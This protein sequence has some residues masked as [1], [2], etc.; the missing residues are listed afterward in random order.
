MHMNDYNIGDEVELT[1]AV[2]DSSKGVRG[3]IYQQSNGSK[4]V[5]LNDGKHVVTGHTKLVKSVTG[6][7]FR[8]YP[9][10]GEYP[11][12]VD[13]IVLACY[14]AEIDPEND[15]RCIKQERY[16]ELSVNDLS[17]KPYWHHAH[18]EDGDE[19]DEPDWWIPMPK[20]FN[21]RPPTKE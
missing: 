12:E 18:S 1:R 3:I 5:Y 15:E 21:E 8:K 9:S 4:A 2:C 17:D 11:A 10:K 6:A 7:T 19:V 16:A 13:D 20:P 14:D